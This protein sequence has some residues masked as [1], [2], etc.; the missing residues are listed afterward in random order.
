[1]VQLCVQ[2]FLFT[3]RNEDAILKV[4]DFGLSDFI[5]YGNDLFLLHDSLHIISLALTLNISNEF[6]CN[7]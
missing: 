7:V 2:N 1:M 6:S 5:R 4:I 3:S